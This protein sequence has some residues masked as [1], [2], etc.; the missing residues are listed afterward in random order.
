MRI[1]NGNFKLLPSVSTIYIYIHIINLQLFIGI[2]LQIIA[3]L[4]DIQIKLWAIKQ[5]EVVVE[6]GEENKNSIT[7]IHCILMLLSK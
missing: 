4:N 2:Y 7:I 6:D 3:N 1:F 5:Y